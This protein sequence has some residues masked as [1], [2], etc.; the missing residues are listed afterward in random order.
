VGVGWRYRWHLPALRLPRLAT[1][2]LTRMAADHLPTGT[3]GAP[4]ARSEWVARRSD[5]AAEH[6]AALG[7]KKAAESAQA[8]HLVQ[9]FV[10]EAIERKLR[11]MPLRARA[12][13]GSTTYRTPLKGWY[14]KRNGSLAVDVEGNYYVM[15]APTSLRARFTG[16]DVAPSDPPLTVGVGGRDGESMPLEHLLR[17]RLD[18]GDDWP[19]AT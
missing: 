6:V 13:N 1:G 19:A 2:T 9:Q 10:R 16:A 15:S 12:Y 17:L 8:R 11:P 18:G 7:R 4:D 5:A 3:E 14:L